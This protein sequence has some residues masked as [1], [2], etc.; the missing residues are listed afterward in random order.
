[1]L[2]IFLIVSYLVENEITN[3][4]NLKQQVFYAPMYKKPHALT[5]VKKENITNCV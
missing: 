4:N 1:M 5:F 3:N 2:I